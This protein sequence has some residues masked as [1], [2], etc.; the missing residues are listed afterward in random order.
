MPYDMML[1][2]EK[3]TLYK[4]G[5]VY[6][7]RWKE[8][9]VVDAAGTAAGDLRCVHCG[10]EVRLHHRKATTGPQDHAEHRRRQDSEGCKGG[11][12]FKGEHRRSASPIE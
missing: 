4:I 5:G 1:T 12:Y 11:H 9:S 3:R 6:E 8:V 10:G 7:K 2:C